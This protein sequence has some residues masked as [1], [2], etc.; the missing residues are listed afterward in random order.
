MI[1]IRIT[2]LTDKIEVNI[3]KSVTF[4]SI[5][6]INIFLGFLIGYTFDN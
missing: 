3:S 2:W 1:L 5:S 6:F 4:A